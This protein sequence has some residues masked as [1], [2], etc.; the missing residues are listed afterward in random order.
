MLTLDH[1]NITSNLKLGDSVE[2][3]HGRKEA[4]RGSLLANAYVPRQ[5]AP[6]PS[7]SRR[8]VMLSRRKRH[9]RCHRCHRCHLKKGEQEGARRWRMLTLDKKIQRATSS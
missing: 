1:K 8:W 7:S 5:R 2:E 6:P 9:G 4:Q 3:G